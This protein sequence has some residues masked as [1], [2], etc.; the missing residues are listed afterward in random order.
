MHAACKEWVFCLLPS[1]TLMIP[2][3][4]VIWYGPR[5]T[6][7]SPLEGYQWIPS[8]VAPSDTLCNLH[9][10]VFRLTNWG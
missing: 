1:L 4:V 6:A 5:E 7:C 9:N 10:I 2:I 3:A 8:T